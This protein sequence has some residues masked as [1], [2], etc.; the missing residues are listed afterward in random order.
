M[1]ESWRQEGH[2][3]GPALRRWSSWSELYETFVELLA[4]DELGI[5]PVE[6]LTLE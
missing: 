5:E 1:V 2:Q 3:T 6:L 4:G